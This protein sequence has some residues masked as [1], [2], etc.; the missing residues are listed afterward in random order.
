MSVHEVRFQ[1]DARVG[2][3][4][5]ATGYDTSMAL[6]FMTQFEGTVQIWIAPPA[7]TATAEQVLARIKGSFRFT[8]K[9]QQIVQ[10]DEMLIASDGVAANMNQQMWFQGQQAVHRAQVAQGDAIVNNYWQQQQ[11]NDGI[12]QSYWNAQHTNERSWQDR[13]NAMLDRQRLYDDSL[14]KHYDAPAGANYYWRDQQG[15]IV[16]TETSDPPDYLNNYTP[17]RKE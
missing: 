2:C 9:I 4:Y 17:L 7:L 10:Q 15:Q 5:A 14:G 8:P 12:A 11:V 13:S 16:G 3:L 6:G 1:V